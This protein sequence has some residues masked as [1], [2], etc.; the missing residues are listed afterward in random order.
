MLRDLGTL[1]RWAAALE[2]DLRECRPG[3]WGVA[4]DDAYVLTVTHD[5]RSEQVYLGELVDEESFSAGPWWEPDQR[6]ATLDFEASEAVAGDLLEVLRL[7]D[8]DRALCPEHEAASWVCCATWLCPGQ[9]FHQLGTVGT[10]GQ[11]ADEP[12]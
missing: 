10:L 11:A 9:P 7:W 6:E 1:R 4:V 3:R 5:G 2:G 12:S 8:V